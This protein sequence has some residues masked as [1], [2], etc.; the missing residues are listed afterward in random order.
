[1]TYLFSIIIIIALIAI[2][3]YVYL[4]I[5][6]VKTFN[7]L[8]CPD[9]RNSFGKARFLTKIYK[10]NIHVNFGEHGSISTTSYRCYC[11][12]CKDVKLV[13]SEELN[14]ISKSI[15]EAEERFKN[16]KT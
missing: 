2:S 15:T 13:H 10:E 1:M 11:R 6:D 12:V 3:I 4:Y 14:N 5:S 7:N 8:K 16:H 9:C